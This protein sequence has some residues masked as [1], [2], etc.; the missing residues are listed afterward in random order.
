MPFEIRAARREEFALLPDIEQ[1]ASLR[2]SAIGLKDIADDQPS[3]PEFIAATDRCGAVFVAAD[4]RSL[5]GFVIAGFL[6]RSLYIYELAVLEGF[7]RR[8]IGAA[9]VEEVC[10]LARRER[11]ASVTLSTFI[12][13]PWN[14]PFY[15]RMGFR[16]LKRDEVDARPPSPPPPRDRQEAA[17]GAAELHAQGSPVTKAL[18]H[19]DRTGAASMVDVGDKPVSERVAIAEGAVVM[20]SKTLATIRAGNAKKGDVIGTARIAGIMAAKR[21]HELIPLCHPIALSAISVEIEPDDALPGLRVR[22]TAKVAER[23]GV[24]MEALTAVSVAC[25]TIYDMAKAIDRGMELTAIRL[26]EKAAGGR[27]AGGE[28]NDR[29]APPRPVSGRSA[30]QSHMGLAAAEARR[31]GR[32]SEP[33]SVGSLP[34]K[35]GGQEGVGAASLGFPN[36]V[37]AP[38]APTLV[39]ARRAVAL[40]LS[41]IA[42][43]TDPL[44][45][46]PFRGRDPT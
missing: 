45:S 5:V 13:V 29:S 10:Q 19:L 36:G 26:V 39:T 12:D 7:G 9:L 2:F 33:V 41:D 43:G 6:D 42:G 40:D 8:G 21:T 4:G 3:T 31:R 15:E 34:L 1:S 32:I 22:A 23:T 28:A 18:T 25:L 35:G 30:G 46:S 20:A 14:G 37:G 16:Y 27:E 24:E 44:L 38:P 11:Q 17:D